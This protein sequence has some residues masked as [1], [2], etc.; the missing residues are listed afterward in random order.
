MP[1]LKKHFFGLFFILFSLIACKPSDTTTTTAN[2]SATVPATPAAPTPAQNAVG[3]N[4]NHF[5]ELALP[6]KIDSSSLRNNKQFRLVEDTAWFSK[7][8]TNIV[9][10]ESQDPDIAIPKYCFH[11]KMAG[12]QYL[13][14][15]LY[16]IESWN[17]E[18]ELLYLQLFSADNKYIGKP[19]QITIRADFNSASVNTL[20]TISANEFKTK[21]TNET[22]DNTGEDDP[23]KESKTISDTLYTITPNG[24]DIKP[25]R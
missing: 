8:Y 22:W 4:I 7:N 11:T 3:P 17:F 1:Q 20:I 19:N 5:P 24:F 13:V 12:N 15:I 16:T 6:L 18:Y 14:G 2:T 23:A 10:E 9:F 25:I 21:T